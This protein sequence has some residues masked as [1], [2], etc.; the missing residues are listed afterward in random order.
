MSMN[1]SRHRRRPN[2][3]GHWA[4]DL[5]GRITISIDRADDPI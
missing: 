1:C 5:H 2:W 4:K 3:G